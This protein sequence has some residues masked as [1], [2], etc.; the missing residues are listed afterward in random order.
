MSEEKISFQND[1][2]VSTSLQMAFEE[3]CAINSKE[4]SSNKGSVTKQAISEMEKI[5]F[6]LIDHI[7][8]N[9]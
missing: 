1:L 5:I 7:K 9:D 3:K 6:K 8:D 2:I 4:H